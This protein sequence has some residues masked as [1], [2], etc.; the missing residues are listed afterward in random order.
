MAAANPA[1]L[2]KTTPEPKGKAKIEYIGEGAKDI[3]FVADPD[4][5]LIRVY[6]D[7]CILTDY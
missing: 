3:K 7:G 1:Q 6:A 2:D 4:A 5:T